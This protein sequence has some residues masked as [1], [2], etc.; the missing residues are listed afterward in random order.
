M[1]DHGVVVLGAGGHAKVVLEVLREQ[2]R[3][4]HGLVDAD[5][6]PRQVLGVPVLGD[7]AILP[8][9]RTQ[10]VTEAFVALGDNQL[11]LRLAAKLSALGFSMPPAVSS[12]STVS[13]SAQ[14]GQGALVAPRAVINAEASVG[15]QTIIN[16]G[17]V[18]EHDCRIDAGAHLGPGAVLTGAVCVGEAAF[19]GAGATVIP[20][21]RIGA[22]AL[23]AAGACVTLDVA[24]HARVAGVPARPILSK[25]AR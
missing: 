7:D 19:V 4:V 25:G 5:P 22:G 17:A 15:D 3:R 24:D 16:T 6:T 9:L 2:G 11:R 1:P 10:G 8:Q 18:V 12:S 14:L 21:R 20:G 23:V 13:R